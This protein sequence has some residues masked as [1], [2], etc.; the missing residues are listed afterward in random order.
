MLNPLKKK[1]W[2]KFIGL[3][4]FLSF[5]LWIGGFHEDLFLEYLKQDSGIKDV[6]IYSTGSSRVQP[7]Y[8]LSAI[9]DTSQLN[10]L[11][12]KSS[13]FSPIKSTDWKRFPTLHAPGIKGDYKSVRLIRKNYAGTY[14]IICVRENERKKI[15]YVKDSMIHNSPPKW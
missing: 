10:S 13:N 4:I 1:F 3:G 9:K 5:I 6:Y 8:L 2:G 11:Y 12:K 7:V 15:L 14:S